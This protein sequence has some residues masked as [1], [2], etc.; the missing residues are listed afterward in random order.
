[1]KNCWILDL[2]VYS[3]FFGLKEQRGTLRKRKTLVMLGMVSGTCFYLISKRPSE[4]K[5]EGLSVHLKMT[6]GFA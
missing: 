5:G 6:E 3:C 4:Y 2:Y 1:M